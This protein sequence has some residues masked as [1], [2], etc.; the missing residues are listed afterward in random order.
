MTCWIATAAVPGLSI[1]IGIIVIVIMYCINIR[2]HFGS[3][4]HVVKACTRKGGCGV[5]GRFAATL[6]HR[7][8][9]CVFV[10]HDLL[11]GCQDV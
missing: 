7:D 1:I 8:S 6:E 4:V 3:R 10:A 11:A 2:S 9:C 5:A